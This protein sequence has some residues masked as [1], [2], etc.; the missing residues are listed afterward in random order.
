MVWDK[1]HLEMKI[2]SEAPMKSKMPPPLPCL[3]GV[4]A[5][6]MC[7]WLWPWPIARHTYSYALV[8]GILL[9]G[10]V[11]VLVTAL[12]RAF[13]RHGTPADPV[14]ETTAIIDTGPFSLSRNPAYLSVA[15]LQA[16]LGFIFNNAWILL[17]ILPAMIVIH[18]VA[19]LREEAYLEAK[20]GDE[21]LKYKSRVRRWI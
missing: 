16:A 17:L 5:G 15:L 1:H 20:F 21:Y 7:D 2:M 9:F 4:I 6:L 3:F 19:V 18:Y 8:V 13:K 12:T 11:I 10:L 14:R